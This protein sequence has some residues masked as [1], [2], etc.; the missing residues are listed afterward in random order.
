MNQNIHLW[1]SSLS[2]RTDDVAIKYKKD[3]QWLEMSSHDYL[4]YIVHFSEIIEKIKSK[5]KITKK[6]NNI[7]LLSHSR[8][9]W[10]AFDIAVVGLH[11][12]MIPLYPNLSDSDLKF[13][14]ENSQPEVLILENEEN[15]KQFNRI[16]KHLQS[17][18]EVLVIDKLKYDK[19]KISNKKI[20]NFIHKSKDIKPDDLVS[21]IYTS[22][23]TGV[24]KGVELQHKSLISEIVDLFNAFDMAPQPGAPQQTSLSFL[25]FAHVM[26]RIELWGSCYAGYTLAFSESIEHLKSNLKEI[27]PD[28]LVAVPRIFE[29]FHSAIINKIETQT[30]KKKLFEHTLKLANQVLFHRQ[31]NIAMDLNLLAQYEILSKIVFKPIREALGGKLKFAICGGAP[32]NPELEVFFKHAGI[33][34]LVGYGLTETFAAATINTP[35]DNKPETVGK[36]LGDVQ[37]KFAEDGEI[38]IK[39]EKCFKGYYK[40]EEANKVAFT[41]DGFFRT[42]DIGELTEDGFLKITDRKKDLIKTSG[43]KY[44]SPQKL[45]N[46]LKINNLI[47]QVLIVGDQRK[48]VTALINIETEVTPEV[49]E[50]IRKHVQK[51][52]SSLSSYESIK[53]FEIIN[54]EWSVSSGCMTPSLKLKRKFLEK[55]YSDLIDSLYY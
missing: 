52:N 38:L 9:E 42:G 7:A 14:L 2:G 40:N 6:Q 26:G 43:G 16:K 30:F 28:F 20:E 22:G 24:P 33:S 17:K 1:I 37:I 31:T 23:T 50:N 13:I 25:P 27:K 11:D 45:E 32:L 15:L 54:E 49:E 47:S 12:I 5:K 51:I 39:S 10:A 36:P 19:I 55:K 41:P 53:R 34:I 48:Y 21:I 18:P 46:L 29:K 8:W 35:T 3:N 4:K 44:I